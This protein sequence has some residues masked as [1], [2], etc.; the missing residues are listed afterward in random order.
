MQKP[1][2]NFYFTLLLFANALVSTAQSV[3]SATER[4]D[5]SISEVFGGHSHLAYVHRK[6][7]AYMQFLMH[8]R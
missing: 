1:G 6:Y 3:L 2:L 5:D 4:A 7:N 8:V